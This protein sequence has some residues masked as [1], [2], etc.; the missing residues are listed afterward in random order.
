LTGWSGSDLLEGQGGNDTLEGKTGDD[1]LS[2]GA[3]DD[4]LQ[5]GDGADI[6][7]GGAGLDQLV[8]GKGNDTYVL[9]A[10]QGGT[11]DYTMLETITEEAGGGLDTLHVIGVRPSDAGLGIHS[12]VGDFTFII[13]T[14]DELLCQR[15]RTEGCRRCGA[16]HSQR[17]STSYDA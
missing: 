16:Q 7:S 8:G 10:R 5:G 13:R 17:W 6:L 14:A 1:R 12:E 3:G 2:G 9:R 11:S 15:W 4:H